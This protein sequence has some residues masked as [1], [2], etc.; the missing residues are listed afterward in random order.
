MRMVHRQI[1]SALGQDLLDHVRNAPVRTF[2]EAQADLLKTH[3][4]IEAAAKQAQWTL[5][6]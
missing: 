4:E 5:W 1:E 6:Q 3:D 2:G